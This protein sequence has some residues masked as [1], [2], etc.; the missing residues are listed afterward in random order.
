M[1]NRGIVRT[2]KLVSKE[3]S[4][5][6]HRV[7][8]SVQYA[9]IRLV[10]L[11]KLLFKTGAFI[12]GTRLAQEDFLMQK[13]QQPL[14]TAWPIEGIRRSSSGTEHFQGQQL[15]PRSFV[16]FFLIPQRSGKDFA[17][18]L[19][20]ALAKYYRCQPVGNEPQ[21]YRLPFEQQAHSTLRNRIMEV[22]SLARLH[23]SIRHPSCQSAIR[24]G[25]SSAVLSSTLTVLSGQIRTAV[26]DRTVGGR[27][28]GF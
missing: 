18:P 23:T 6:P 5:A 7:A 1:D 24:F 17:H 8:R 3:C 4:Q 13:V 28:K 15:A 9:V 22:K 14:C 26:V 11:P 20:R 16:D 25:A 21:R 2:E 27:G 19:S 10:P 12:R